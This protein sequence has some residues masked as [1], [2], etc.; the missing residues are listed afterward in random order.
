ME[1]PVP[2]TLRR[3]GHLKYMPDADVFGNSQSPLSLRIALITLT[4]PDG[5]HREIKTVEMHGMLG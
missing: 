4:V 3:P 2:G 1:K 5:V